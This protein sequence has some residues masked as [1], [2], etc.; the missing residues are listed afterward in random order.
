MEL[1]GEINEGEYFGY[2]LMKWLAILF[3]DPDGVFS[4][5]FVQDREPY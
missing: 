2:P 3:I 4:L 5:C 1:I